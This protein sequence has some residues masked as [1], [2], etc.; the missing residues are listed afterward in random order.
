M[1]RAPTIL[2]LTALAITTLACGLGGGEPDLPDTPP[3]VTPPEDAGMG[4]VQE[5]RG[6]VV[7]LYRDLLSQGCDPVAAGIDSAIV[8]R[9]LRNAPYAEAGRAFKS[10]ELDALFRADLQEDYQPQGEGLRL[11]A[12]DLACVGKLKGHEDALRRVQCIDPAGEAALI[13]NH[14]A[15]LWHADQGMAGLFHDADPKTRTIPKDPGFD[16]CKGERGQTAEDWSFVRYEFE[17]SEVHD[18]AGVDAAVSFG[19]TY[20]GMPPFFGNI[21]EE[22]TEERIKARLAQALQEGT[23]VLAFHAK[24]YAEDHMGEIDE[25]FEGMEDMRCVGHGVD[26]MEKSSWICGGIALP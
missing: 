1:T 22:G 14:R 2:A 17:I 7:N 15:F 23:P 16:A 11:D 10:P 4:E 6:E 26:F 8:A 25:W 5:A 12:P 9:V 21:T 20:G 13:S 18:M 19:D 3:E 24:S